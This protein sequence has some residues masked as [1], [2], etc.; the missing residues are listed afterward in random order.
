MSDRKESFEQLMDRLQKE[1]VEMC[2]EI[3]G[4]K[5]EEDFAVGRIVLAISALKQ[6][7]CKR[8]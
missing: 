1:L 2:W 3:K 8:T 5:D 7:H 6:L 4:P